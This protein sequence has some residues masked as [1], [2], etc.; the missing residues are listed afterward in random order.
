MPNQIKLL[1]VVSSTLSSKALAKV[2]DKVI[3]LSR[4]SFVM[5]T[6][7]YE[8]KEASV[9]TTYNRLKQRLDNLQQMLIECMKEIEEMKVKSNDRPS[10]PRSRSKS[11]AY[12]RPDRSMCYYHHRFGNNANKLHLVHVN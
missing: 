5:A 2:A 1:L 3:E 6:T 10:R 11:Q 7:A 12:Q 8:Q 4:S 9:S